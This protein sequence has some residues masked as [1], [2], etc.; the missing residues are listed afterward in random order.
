MSDA[1]VKKREWHASHGD[2]FKSMF[3]YLKHISTLATGS[4]LLIATFLEKLFKQP[5][6]AWY[7]GLSVGALFTSLVASLLAY[8]VLVLNYPRVDDRLHGRTV[9]DTERNVFAGGIIITWIS[10]VIG[11]GAM[12]V[13]FLVN[14]FAG[15]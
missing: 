7:V 4:L 12:A 5:L 11:I 14:W 8:S 6:H 3:D 9:T 13:F 2:H 15:P 10:F 1:D